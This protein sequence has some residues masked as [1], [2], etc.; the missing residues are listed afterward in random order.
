MIESLLLGEEGCRPSYSGGAACRP[1]SANAGRE[2][3]VL[4]HRWSSKQD[5]TK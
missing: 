4:N 5:I 1:Q 2:D 3:G